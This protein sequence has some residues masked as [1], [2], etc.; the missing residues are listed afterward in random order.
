[1]SVKRRAGNV[2]AHLDLL[3]KGEDACVFQTFGA[4]L[5]SLRV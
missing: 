1:M 2:L 3:I 4:E 5:V